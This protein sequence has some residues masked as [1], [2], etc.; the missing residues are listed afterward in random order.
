MNA[1]VL[2]AIVILIIIPL[3]FLLNFRVKDLEKRL[4]SM[5]ISPFDAEDRREMIERCLS[6]MSLL[7]IYFKDELGLNGEYAQAYSI[8]EEVAKRLQ[9]NERCFFDLN[10]IDGERL[11]FPD[12]NPMVCDVMTRGEFEEWSQNIKADLE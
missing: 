5:H 8:A 10:I 3:F 6:I 1:L 2:F 12:N 4:N 9:E 7:K 11:F